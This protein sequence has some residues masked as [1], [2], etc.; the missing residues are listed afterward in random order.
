MTAL[1]LKVRNGAPELPGM[2]A[3]AYVVP[4]FY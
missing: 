4:L 1:I 3:L 2:L